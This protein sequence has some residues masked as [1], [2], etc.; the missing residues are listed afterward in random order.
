MAQKEKAT[1][2]GR[3]TSP[4]KTGIPAEEKQAALDH[5]QVSGIGDVTEDGGIIDEDGK[6]LGRKGG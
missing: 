5:A 3:R 4:G 2:A 1:G 6:R